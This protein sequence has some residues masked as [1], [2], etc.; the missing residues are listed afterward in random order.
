MNKRIIFLFIAAVI[1]LVVL[2]PVAQYNRLVKIDQKV[3]EAWA[4]VENV[5]QRR[6][7]LIPNL[8]E[9]VKGYAKHERE[10]FIEVTQARTSLMNAKT[11]PEKAAASTQ[12]E[13]A[14]S[15]LLLV[16]ENYPQLKASENFSKLQDELA[17]TENR[18]AVER[19]RYNQAVNT[20]NKIAKSFPALV[21]VDMFHFDKEKPYFQA[22]TESQTPP[23]V[24]FE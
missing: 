9:T 11:V 19:M 12:L 16:V 22:T 14:L 7:D 1:V 17:G 13:N 21:F 23:A 18:I 6:N 10:V 4:Q 3:K 5:L 2:Y 8:V 24:K 15:R 20:Y